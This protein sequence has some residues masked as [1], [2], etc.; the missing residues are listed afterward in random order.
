MSRSQH[1]SDAACPRAKP[2]GHRARTPSAPALGRTVC[3]LGPGAMA[4]VDAKAA[5]EVIEAVPKVR[6]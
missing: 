5:D 1:S 2:D 6:K 3:K 4:A